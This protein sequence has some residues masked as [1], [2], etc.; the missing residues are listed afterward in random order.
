MTRQ[1]KK[2]IGQVV[3]V[4]MAKTAIVS[5]D[6]VWQHPL[7]KKRIKRTKKYACHDE[8]GVKEGDKVVIQECR[9][10][11]KTKRWK[12]IKKLK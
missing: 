12:I 8:L 10:M 4:K 3:S 7:Y 6:R 11:S 1:A 5:V 2:N 9:P